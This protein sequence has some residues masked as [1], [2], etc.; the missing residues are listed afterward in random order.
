[1]VPHFD[2]ADILTPEA[3]THIA[4]DNEKEKGKNSKN[5]LEEV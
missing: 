3:D 4:E 1:M 2:N 5:K